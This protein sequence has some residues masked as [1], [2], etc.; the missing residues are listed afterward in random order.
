MGDKKNKVIKMI[1]SITHVKRWVEKSNADLFELMELPVKCMD[2]GK[3][4]KLGD[5]LRVASGFLIWGKRN[6]VSYVKIG[7]TYCE[8]YLRCSRCGSGLIK[9]MKKD[10][11][12]F[13]ANVV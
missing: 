10:L 8:K 1:I 7:N 5:C 3:K 13:I 6:H 9:I 2:C 4:Q 12:D 11:P